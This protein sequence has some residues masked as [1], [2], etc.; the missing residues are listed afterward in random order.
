M[1]GFLQSPP[2]ATLM[3]YAHEERA[4]R[5]FSR[6]LDIGCGAGRNAGPL[7]EAGFEVIGLDLSGP[8]L[9]G[10]RSR[11]RAGSGIVHLARSDMDH[12]PIR[13]RS[14]DLVIA[15]GI[16][17]LAAS[18]AEFRG[19]VREA[20]RISKP[21]AGLFVFTFSRN[22]LDAEAS[23]VRGETFIYTQ[24]SGTPQCFLTE[25]QLVSELAA[26][27]FTLDQTT[28]TLTEHNSPHPGQLRSPG[29]PVIFE[30][31]FRFTP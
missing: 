4:R 10:A 16:W 28:V 27:G 30:G 15:H 20:A 21:G 2:N 24:F 29:G 17:N 8:M 23:P 26:G 25:K 7:A 12:L 14:V 19:A 5:P 18:G 9:Q 31:A 1:A 3:R 13:D 22:T 11:A 6:I